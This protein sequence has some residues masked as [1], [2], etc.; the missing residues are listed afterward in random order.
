MRVLIFSHTFPRFEGDN[1]APFMG[2][3]A[4]SLHKRVKDLFVFIP[5]DPKIKKDRG[6]KI[7]TFKYAFFDRFHLLGYS[8]TLQDDKK[9]RWYVNLLAPL[10][11]LFGF[12]SLLKL[13]RSKNIDLISAHWII[14]NG[15]IA[16]LVTW[17]YNVPYTV[18]IPG[19]DVYLSGKNRIFYLMTKLAAENADAVISDNLRYLEQL[20]KLGIK[21]KKTKIINY[22][23]NV[24]SFKIR[25]KDKELISKY[26]LLEND[27]IV[28]AVG[29]LVQ[30]KGFIYLI[31]AARNLKEK[32]RNFKL[33]IVGDGNQRVLLEKECAKYN[34]SNEVIFT[35]MI[36]YTAL[37]KYYNLADVF[38]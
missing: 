30:K 32:I 24:D 18:T 23:V 35:G 13:V 28:L 3:L 4:N 14:P 19:S 29:R 31:R 21:P 8:R 37:T 10:Y 27:F 22:G 2:N 34:L 36:D 26:N 16:Y 38:V 17:I 12:I 6:Y 1:S 15:F 11:I 33:V 20:K 7:K 5:Y 25:N 9:L